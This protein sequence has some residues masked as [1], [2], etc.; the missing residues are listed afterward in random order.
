MRQVVVGGIVFEVYGWVAD[1]SK[2]IYVDEVDTAVR[3]GCL[4][5]DYLSTS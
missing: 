3:M 2:G 4:M 5:K 1:G